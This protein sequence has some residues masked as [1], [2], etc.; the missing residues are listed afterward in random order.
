MRQITAAFFISVDGVVEAPQNWHFPY[1][2]PD[3]AAEVETQQSEASAFLLG[4]R[5]YEEWAGYWPHQDPADPLA[6]RRN[7]TRKCVASRTLDEVGWANS[8]LLGCDAVEAVARL[9]AE[10][11]PPLAVAG[12]P[13]L[14]RSLLAAGLVTELRLV[15]HPLVVGK[16]QRLFDDSSNKIGL[17]LVDLQRHAN[18]V[19]VVV[20]R[21]EGS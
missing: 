2:S 3:M 16:G 5:T 4:R 6:H 9:A 21:P 8:E 7:T 1:L 17:T 13:T 10:S 15:V 18:G 14:F 12:S 20:Y 11:G 19:A